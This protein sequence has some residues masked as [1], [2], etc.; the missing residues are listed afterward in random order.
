VGVVEAL[1]PRLS[2]ASC[3]GLSLHSGGSVSG[4]RRMP[5]GSQIPLSAPRPPG[6]AIGC[7]PSPTPLHCP[8]A[9]LFF[10]RTETLPEVDPPRPPRRGL[11]TEPRWPD[12]AETSVYR[13][14][15]V[16]ARL[17]A[18]GGRG[19]EPRRQRG[20]LDREPERGPGCR[21]RRGNEPGGDGLT[22]PV[23]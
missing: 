5:I 1:I 10:W 14:S 7:R 18:R 12:A 11:L 13:A 19:D 6:V 16:T 23:V 15:R 4:A 22:P 21:G 2:S 20:A 17:G 9:S 3:A 8:L